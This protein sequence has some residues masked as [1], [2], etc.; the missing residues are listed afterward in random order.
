MFAF[1]NPNADKKAEVRH[2]QHLIVRLMS[3][4]HC[5]GLQSVACM[6]DEA[7]DIFDLEGIGEESIAHLNANKEEKTLIILQWIQKLVIQSMGSGIINVA[8]PVASRLFQQL[9]Q[10]IG[11]LDRAKKISD[12]PFPFPYTQ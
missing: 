11:Q 3:L 6:D 8:P 9:G 1:C 7:F 2:F 12:I 5:A 10:G 4:L